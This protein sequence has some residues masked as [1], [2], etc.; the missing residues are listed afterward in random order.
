MLPKLRR[1][2]SV[3]RTN[4]NNNN[5]QSTDSNSSGKSTDDNTVYVETLLY[6]VHVDDIDVPIPMKEKIK[7]EMYDGGDEQQISSSNQIVRR[8]SKR[9]TASFN[10]RHQLTKPS[11]TFSNPLRRLNSKLNFSSLCTFFSKSNRFIANKCSI[12]INST[13]NIECRKSK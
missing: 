4:S 11:F 9:T 3:L 6:I 2:S 12:D 8:F 1:I 13:A 5:D 10:E 7:E